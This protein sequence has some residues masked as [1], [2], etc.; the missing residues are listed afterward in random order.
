M[1]E[2]YKSKC[3]ILFLGY[4]S[5]GYMYRLVDEQLESSPTER[6]LKILADSKSRCLRSHIAPATTSVREGIVPL[7]CV[8]VH[9]YLEHFVLFGHHNKRRI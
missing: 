1:H 9:P 3:W 6:D 2:V 8:L 5:S 7:C 4:D